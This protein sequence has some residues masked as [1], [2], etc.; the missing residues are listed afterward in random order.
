[1]SQTKKIQKL[2][3]RIGELEFAVQHLTEMV[4][5]IH[6]KYTNFTDALTRKTL[7]KM[8]VDQSSTD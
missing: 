2:E 7:E 4:S 8:L 3:E 1:M 6:D 5:E